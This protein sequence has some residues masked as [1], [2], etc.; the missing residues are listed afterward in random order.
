LDVNI[1]NP[2]FES[3]KGEFLHDRARNIILQK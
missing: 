2:T 3:Q 1:G